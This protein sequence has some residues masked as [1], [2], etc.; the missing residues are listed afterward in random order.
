MIASLDTLIVAYQRAVRDLE[1]LLADRE[2]HVQEVT[3]LEAL[4]ATAKDRTRAAKSEL[5]GAIESA[6]T[7]A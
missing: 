4:I 6:D 1:M 5:L 7:D 3:R 2:Q